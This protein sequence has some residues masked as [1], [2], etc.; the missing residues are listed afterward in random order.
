MPQL[1]IIIPALNAAAH[2][3]SCLAALQTSDVVLLVDGGS[4][5]D[6][7]ARAQQLGAV[8]VAAPRGRGSQLRAGAARART[9]WMLFL[10]ADTV[11]EMGWRDEVAVFLSGPGND[12]RAAVF[13]FALDDTAPEARR[14]E[15]W[16]EWRTRVLGLPYGDQGLLIHRRLY[17]SI[18]GYRPIPIMEDVDIMRRIGR[19]QIVLLKSRAATSAERW[20]R[21]GWLGRSA[22]NMFCLSLY[23]LGVPPRSIARIYG[24]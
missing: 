17:E 9:E 14:L 8:V 20:R 24:R 21:D 1:T 23:F 16:V 4:G 6:T 3:P 12:Q 22:R 15:R 19:R 18:G 5:D 13:H 2:L 7:A 11:L 10:H